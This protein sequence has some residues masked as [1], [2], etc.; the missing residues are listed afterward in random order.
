MI[1]S[2]RAERSK[3]LSSPISSTNERTYVCT[4]VHD[5]QMVPPPQ[6]AIGELSRVYLYEAQVG[7]VPEEEL[8]SGTRLGAAAGDPH[9]P[10]GHRVA[11]VVV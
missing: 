2:I 5:Q 3:A 6:I 11:V 1:L 7:N 4:Y 10:P 9:G 8:G